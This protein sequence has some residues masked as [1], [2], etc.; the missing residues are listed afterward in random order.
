MKTILG[1][2]V[3]A[4]L[5]AVVVCGC[6]A[7]TGASPSEDKSPVVPI[8]PP[9][10]DVAL[11][12]APTCSVPAR[13][14][15]APSKSFAAPVP[16]SIGIAFDGS[17]LWI[18]NGGVSEPGERAATS[19]VRVNPDTFAVEATIAL[20]LPDALLPD[21][22]MGGLAWDGQQLWL[23]DSTSSEGS[24]LRIDPT[25]GEVT[26]RV[27]TPPGRGPVAVYHDGKVL[28]F[29]TGGGLV[30]KVDPA[31]GDMLQQFGVGGAGSRD[32]GIAVRGCEV[33]VGMLVNGGVQIFDP[34]N[35][36]QVANVVDDHG[37]PFA[38]MGRSVFVGNQLV[39]A[40]EG[41]IA[42]YDVVPKP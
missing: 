32:D 28:W 29:S 14:A 41:E 40:K 33:W 8:E 34:D 11:E 16:L 22:V 38:A 27:W 7:S 35:G 17:D 30:F 26:Q 42:Y 5:L 2:A 19:L 31:S 21:T 36:I 10:D 12:R 18:L 39:V 25:S 4:G 1:A 9:H 6:S 13:Y 37:A 3:S 24:L 20:D 23:S 15:L